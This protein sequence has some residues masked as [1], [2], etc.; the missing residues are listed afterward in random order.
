[1]LIACVTGTRNRG[2]LSISQR[3]TITKL[4]EKNDRYKRYIKNWRSNPLLDV[5]TKI[6]SK[7]LSERLKN[8]LSSLISTRQ[9]VY[10]RNRFIGEG[11]RLISYIVNIY[12]HISILPLYS[13][14]RQPNFFLKDENSIVHLSEKIKLFSD[15]S[16]LKRNLKLL[17]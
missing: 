11:G 5:A 4:M 13:L 17:E 16:G 2:E 6:I 3:Q 14:C 15:F 7:A 1:M 10:I 12:D 9:T 8:V